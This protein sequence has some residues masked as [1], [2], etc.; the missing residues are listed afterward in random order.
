MEET[1]GK[2]TDLWM[3]TATV[4]GLSGTAVFL[5]WGW[6]AGIFASQEAMENFLK[7]FGLWAPILFILLQM[8][9]VVLPILPGGISCLGGVVLFGPLEGF[10]YNYSGICLGSLAAFCLA[11][12]YGRPLV[13]TLV[14]QRAYEKYSRWLDGG[15]RFDRCFAAAIF[16][17]VA[18]DDLL[19]Y[20]AGLTRMSVKKFTAIILLGK[21]ASIALYS[22]GLLM[23]SR[24]VAQVI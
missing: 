22:M 21:P 14:G 1:G 7:P 20:L 16:F 24:A 2:R 23:V 17:P 15:R 10:L 13:R 3:K 11:K 9:Q 19:C 5:I 18:P 8:V 6:R 4:L 12:R